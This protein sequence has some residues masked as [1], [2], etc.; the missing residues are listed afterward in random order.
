MEPWCCIPRPPTDLPLSVK[1]LVLEA[2]S[3]VTPLDSLEASSVTAAAA[4]PPPQ[5]ASGQSETHRAPGSSGAIEC[6]GQAT[7]RWVMGLSCRSMRSH[8]VR[9]M[10]PAS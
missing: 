8:D 10:E 3:S 9:R 1:W 7:A 4:Q 6:L 5:A 2:G